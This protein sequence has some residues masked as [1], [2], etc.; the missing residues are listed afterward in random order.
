MVLMIKFC[1]PMAFM[2][3]N[4][5]AKYGRCTKSDKRVGHIPQK[6]PMPYGFQK[7]ETFALGKKIEKKS[8][9]TPWTS[10]VKK[11]ILQKN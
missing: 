10:K 1:Q 11:S 6:K 2:H 3:T 5:C 7:Y 8:K 9:K 4:Q